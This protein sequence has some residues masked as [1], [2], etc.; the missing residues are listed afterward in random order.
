MGRKKKVVEFDR[1]RLSLL[2]RSEKL[3]IFSEYNQLFHYVLSIIPSF[4]LEVNDKGKAESLAE[5]YYK[6]EG[7]EVYRSKVNGGYRSIGVEFYWQ[8]FAS[9]ITEQDRYLIDKLKSLMPAEEFKELAF[10]VREK[11]GTP[12]LLLIKSDKI[13]FVEVKY[14]YETVKSST[15]EFFIRYGEKWPTSILR[16]LRK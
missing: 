5:I 12:D 4:D 11:N 15:I 3:D 10:M 13:S 14:N 16:V 2:S 8:S 9:K 6:Q 7:Y 1:E